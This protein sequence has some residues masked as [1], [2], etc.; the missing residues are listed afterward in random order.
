MQKDIPR[1]P[2]QAADGT[3]RPSVR[4]RSARADHLLVAGLLLLTLACAAVGADDA[5]LEISPLKPRV[6]W[7]EPIPVRITARNPTTSHLDGRITL[8]F[9]GPVLITSQSGAA[10]I[11]YEG[12]VIQRP[13]QQPGPPLR[14]VTLEEAFNQWDA[15]QRRSLDLIFLPLKLGPLQLRA[16]A[17]FARRGAGG[18]RI[19]GRVPAEALAGVRDQEGQ[20]VVT[21]GL[22]VISSQRLMRNLARLAGHS[23]PA[24]SQR[25]LEHLQRL[26]ENPEDPAHWARFGFDQAPDNSLGYI[27]SVTAMI[28]DVQF[29]DDPRLMRYLYRLIDSPEDPEARAFFG[30]DGARDSAEGPLW[31]AQAAAEQ[32]A[33]SF[34]E[35]LRAGPNLIFILDQL[36]AFAYVPGDTERIR[37][38]YAGANHSVLRNEDAVLAIANLIARHGSDPAQITKRH[39]AAGNRSLMD[40]IELLSRR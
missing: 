19:I 5:G 39:A 11:Y 40:I 30:L 22:Q 16:R 12:D 34:L 14:D 35:T 37:F 10:S 38:Y 23:A 28:S 29:V 2:R 17:T 21:A 1:T 31:Q 24:E 32:A 7:G 13:G 8:S 6:Q 26:F 15:R 25:Y 18:G 9:S 3:A 36:P 20:P 27:K 33:K 4:R